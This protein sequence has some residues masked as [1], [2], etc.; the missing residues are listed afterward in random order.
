MAEPKKVLVVEDEQPL[1]DALVEKCKQAGFSVLEARNGKEGLEIAL[2]EHPDLILLDLVMPVMDG[3]TMLH[4]LRRDPWGKNV[5]VL[6]LSNLQNVEKKQD[7]EDSGVRDFMI[8][9]EWKLNDVIEKVK[10]EM[11]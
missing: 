5:S 6:V 1:L 10:E 11:T 9:T 2:K 7:L 8:K 4:H 3:I